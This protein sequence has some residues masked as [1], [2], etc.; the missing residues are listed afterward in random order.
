[1]MRTKMIIFKRTFYVLCIMCF[2]LLVSTTIILAIGGLNTD[3]INS[4]APK[5]PAQSSFTGSSESSANTS[6]TP[7]PP[8]TPPPPQTITISAVGD[9]MLHQGNLNSAYDSK[10]RR[11]DFNG[12]FEFVKPYLSSSDLTIANF[13]TVTAGAGIKYRSFPLFNSPDSILPALSGSGV[14][15]LSTANNHCLD[16]GINGLTRT[17]QKIREYK[18][19]NIGSSVNGKDKYVIK[20]V[21]G[22]K[23]A[24]LSYSQ[25]FNGHEA[26]L[27]S[28]DKSKY[29]SILNESKIQNDIKEVKA[30]GVDTVIT[31]LHWGN[32]YIRTPSTYQTNLS[33]KVLSWGA[34]IILGSHPHV[35]QKSEIVKVNGK[36]KF[37][38]YSMGNFISGYR[39][40]DKA[41]RINKV[42]TEDG[43]I[44]TLKLNKDTKGGIN[45]K[46]VTYIPTWVDMYSSKNKPV[47]KIL[48]VPTPDVKAPYINSRNKSYVKQSYNN[49]MSI[50]AKF[51]SK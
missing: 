41:K 2:L 4:A 22:I 20:D 19:V 9:I 30:K 48:P 38:I 50:M 23:I 7:K 13:E 33:K 36:N 46:D 29:L 31:V 24:I 42:Y 5:P 17:I 43:V 37:I 26:K 27:S 16:W 35:I 40:T 3:Q 8:S 18:M 44:V 11:Y 45:I 39:R 15:I 34:D 12:F 21:K 28:S 51:N 10:S 32:E 47:Y 6:D 25:F 49:T 14:D 1:M